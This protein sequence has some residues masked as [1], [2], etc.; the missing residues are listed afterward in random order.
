M[1]TSAMT[2]TVTAVPGKATMTSI[3]TT[4]GKTTVR[5]ATGIPAG[6]KPPIYRSPVHI[7]PV[8][9]SAIA[10]SV[11][12]PATLK[13]GAVKPSAIKISGIGS[14]KE[15]PIMGIVIVVPIVAIPS[16][17]VIICIARKFVFEICA[18]YCSGR[19][20]IL[21]NG[22]RLLIDHRWW[23]NIYPGTAVGEA[24]AG[25]DIDLGLAGGSDQTGSYYC[26]E[27]KERF[28]NL[29]F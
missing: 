8:D 10:I 24:D 25:I 2:P 27:C 1:T 15:R 16:R 5:S 18:V 26:G 14:F 28:H 4:S 29:S 9:I 3:S 13:P 20:F 7:T 12:K 23:G 17:I 19:I 11:A 21:I 22:C 6:S